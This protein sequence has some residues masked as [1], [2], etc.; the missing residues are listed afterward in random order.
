[1]M[2]ASLLASLA[3]AATA[4]AACPALLDHEFRVLAGQERVKLC[5]RFAGRVL[6]VV[7]TA[8]KCGFTRQYEGLEKL[9]EELAP[10]GFAVLGFPSDDFGGQEFEDEKQIAEFCTNTYAVEFPLFEKTDVRG[11]E[12]NPLF[13][14]LAALAGAPRWN[15]HKYLIGRD[16]ALIA[17]FGS[18]TTPDDAE[19]RQAIERAL[20]A[21]AQDG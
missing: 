14:Q 6:L 3:F 8:S 7:N 20:A 19:L 10:R 21:P 16:G 5:E 12:A 18:R 2:R 17:S 9:H 11:E 1:M 13:A 15:F 4:Q